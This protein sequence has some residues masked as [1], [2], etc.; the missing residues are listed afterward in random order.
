MKMEI[1]I[2]MT[3]SS[4]GPGIKGEQ[5]FRFSVWWLSGLSFC[6]LLLLNVESITMFG[7]AVSSL[8]LI[9]LRLVPKAVR[10]F[11]LFGEHRYRHQ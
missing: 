2:S 1:N 3:I 4:V 8:R 6:L 9:I 5:Y 11:F 7:E 10:L